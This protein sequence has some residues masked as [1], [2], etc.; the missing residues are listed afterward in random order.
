[1]VTNCKNFFF[2]YLRLFVFADS[3]A[4][5]SSVNVTSTESDKTKVGAS[6]KHP[7]DG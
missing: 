5:W 1:M 7:Q 4:L 2:C 3:L 6:C